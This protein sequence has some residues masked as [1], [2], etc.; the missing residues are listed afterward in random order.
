[1]KAYIPLLI[2]LLFSLILALYP[3]HLFENLLAPTIFWCSMLLLLLLY[4][5]RSVMLYVKNNF[6]RKEV[7]ISTL[8]YFPLHLIIF[9]LAMERILAFLFSPQAFY[10]ESIS[11]AYTPYYPIGIAFLFNFLFNPAVEVLLP[12]YYYLSITPF[13]VFI[14]SIIT[15]LVSAN[16]GKIFEFIRAKRIVIAGII[17]LGLVGGTT[18][19]LSLPTLIA[20]YTP[21]SILAYNVVAGEII[22]MVYFVLPIIV[23]VS[24]YDLFKRVVKVK[25]DYLD[26]KYFSKT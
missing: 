21:L 15:L 19:C 11:L 14:A 26:F 24:L 25:Y 2:L 7:K 10:Y 9:S 3:I 22:T 12:P 17:S 8:A 5:I 23:I 16:I 1:M 6:H 20:F 4:P 13:S 18:C